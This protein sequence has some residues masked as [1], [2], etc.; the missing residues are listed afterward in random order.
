[1]SFRQS[2]QAPYDLTNM[3][4]K[5]LEE[6][7]LETLDVRVR[8]LDC[9]SDAAKLQRGVAG[10]RGLAEVKVNPSAARV[11]LLFD[12]AATTADDLKEKLEAIGFPPQGGMAIP[13]PPKP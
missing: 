9:E 8:G 2:H 6:A 13:E 10:T 1:M 4:T 5:A 3:E 7:R 11:T 12:P